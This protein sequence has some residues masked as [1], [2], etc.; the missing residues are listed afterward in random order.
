MVALQSKGSNSSLN[1]LRNSLATAD[2]PR[3]GSATGVYGLPVPPDNLKLGGS[4]LTGDSCAGTPNNSA[5]NSP[6]CWQTP[7]LAKP[8]NRNNSDHPPETKARGFGAFNSIYDVRHSYPNIREKYEP[9]IIQE[10]KSKDAS[11]SNVSG[12]K[13][14]LKILTFGLSGRD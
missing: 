4:H 8:N 13:R 10:N 11:R 14:I 12:F 9:F 5:R 1:N 2:N 3:R 6:V 7:S